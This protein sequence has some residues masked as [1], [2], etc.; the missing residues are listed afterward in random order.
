MDVKNYMLGGVFVIADNVELTPR[1]LDEYISCHRQLVA[2]KYQRLK[3]AYED[4]YQILSAP[5]KPDYKPD[6]RIPVN[7]AKYIVDT[8]NGFFSPTCRLWRVS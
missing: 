6:N 2:S 5:K 8:M 3:D 1:L 7:F 4:K